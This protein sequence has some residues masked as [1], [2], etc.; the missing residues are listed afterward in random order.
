MGIRG[1][2]TFT[3][4]KTQ[5]SLNWMLST[6]LLPIPAV[7]FTFELNTLRFSPFARVFLFSGARMIASDVCVK[8]TFLCVGEQ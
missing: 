8:G 2:F 3:L 1:N 4:S 5:K 7:L 6:I